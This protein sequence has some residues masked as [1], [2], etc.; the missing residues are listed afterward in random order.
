MANDKPPKTKGI[1]NRHL[2][3]RTTFLYHAATYLTLQAGRTTRPTAAPQA[4]PSETVHL[5]ETAIPRYSPLALQLGDHLRTVSRKGQV[6]LSANLKRT[7]CKTCNTVLVPGH[8]STQVV[9]N[10]SKGGKK[11]WADVLVVHCTV[12]GTKKRFPVGATK[13]KRKSEREAVK[14]S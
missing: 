4:G 5:E 8:T 7:V 1:A 6:R 9:E 10:A 12:C 3:A 2:H 13:R 11:P 14:M